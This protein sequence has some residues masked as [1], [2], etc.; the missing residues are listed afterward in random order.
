MVKR[1][2]KVVTTEQKGG[3]S[4][5][6]LLGCDIST[7]LTYIESKF[8]PGMNWDNY[9]SFWNLEYV[10]SMTSSSEPRDGPLGYVRPTT[11]V[12]LSRFH[13]EN[14][15]PKLSLTD[16]NRVARSA[17][18][19]PAAVELDEVEIFLQSIYDEMA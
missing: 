13:Y 9:G 15:I 5:V 8:T 11:M 17:V 3:R 14:V 18:V 12:K 19:Q 16:A 1:L 4:T 2:T 7:F 10:V 6:G